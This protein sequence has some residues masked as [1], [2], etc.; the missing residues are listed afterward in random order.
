MTALRTALGQRGERVAARFLRRR[1]YRILHRNWRCPAGEIDL[2]CADGA[3]LVFVEVKSRSADE[4][5]P[6]EAGVGHLKQ[7]RLER[8]ALHYL[9]ARALEE[10]DWRFDVVSVTLRPWRRP[11]V[12]LLP[13]AF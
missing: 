7:R 1:G 13:G 6:P 8:L 9:A 5:V 2:V 4:V 12:R 3:T 11:A 10:V